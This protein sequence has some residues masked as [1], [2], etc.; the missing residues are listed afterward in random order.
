MFIFQYIS[1]ELHQM[2][3]L[4]ENQQFKDHLRSIIREL[5]AQEYFMEFSHCESFRV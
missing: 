5:T 1:S 3:E 2:V 4:Q